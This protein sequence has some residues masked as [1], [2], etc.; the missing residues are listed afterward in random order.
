MDASTAVLTLATVM[1]LYMAWNIGA[2]DVANAMGTSVGSGALTI[3]RAIIVAAIF[4]FAGAFL[5]GGRVASTIQKGIIEIGALG[6]DPMVLASG[7]TCCLVA[8]ALW[9]NIASMRGWPVSTT[10]SIVG[11]VAGF[12]IAAGGL[13]AVQWKA[14]ATIVASWVVSPLLGGALGFAMFVLVRNRI[15]QREQPLVA[16]ARWGPYMLFPVFGMLTLAVIYKG[17]KHLHLDLPLVQAMPIAAAVGATASLVSLPILRRLAK[18]GQGQDAHEHLRRTEQVFLVLQVITASYVAFAH[19]SNDVANAVGPLAAVFSAFQQGVTAEVEVSANILLI[20]AVGIV[21]GL[22]TF[23]YRVMG[24]VGREITELTPSRGFSAELST[25]STILVASMIGLPVSTT[26]T[27]VGAVVG[28][29]F[30]RSIGAINL[31]VVSGIVASWF[32]TV[33]FTGGIAA[34]LYLIAEAFFL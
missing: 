20:G 26:H 19:G 28:V 7:M 16:L 25:A 34:A 14:M 4:E 33:P 24:T 22:A 15:L 1:G 29:G 2:N 27:L 18:H 3:R 30:A 6:T 21:I 5:A 17:L 32:I 13:G 9:L 11:A 10:H 23:G 12:G 8:A 31:Q